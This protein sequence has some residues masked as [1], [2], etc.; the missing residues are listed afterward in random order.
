MAQEQ[1]AVVAEQLQ[2]LRLVTQLS[3]QES[4]THWV[5]TV[6]VVDLADV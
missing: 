2:S 3:Q 6:G 4:V 5:V 1:L